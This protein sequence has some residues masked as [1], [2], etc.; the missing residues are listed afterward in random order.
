MGDLTTA[1]V[2][3]D[4]SSSMIVTTTSF[5]T[6]VSGSLS[7]GLWAT[8][9]RAA[10]HTV[11]R[12]RFALGIF[13]LGWMPGC[14][15][16]TKVIGSLSA[17]EVTQIEDAVDSDLRRRSDARYPITSIEHTT[18]DTVQVWYAD[19]EARWEEAGYLLERATNGWKITAQ[20]GR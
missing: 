4:S 1:K 3:K 20:L 18:H 9:M 13:I 7:L 14:Q 5:S 10:L 2:A 6:R 19:K 8:T 11:F 15:P 12:I 16:S 17:T